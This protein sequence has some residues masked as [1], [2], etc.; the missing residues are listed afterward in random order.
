[1]RSTEAGN[2]PYA[3][4]IAN[5]RSIDARAI[6]IYDRLYVGRECSGVDESRRLLIDDPRASR[7]H[8]E[9]HIEPEQGVAYVIDSST[10]GTRLN[11][12]RIERSVPV[13][14]ESGDTLSVGVVPLEFHSEMLSN[15][16]AA[17][18]RTTTQVTNANFVMVVSD[19]VD[20][21][22]ASRA[23]EPIGHG[24]PRD[25]AGTLDPPREYHGTLS[26]FVGGALL[27]LGV[28]PDGR[29][30]ELPSIS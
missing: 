7:D 27:S 4:L 12:V 24:E 5:P 11:G 19:I 15:P 10:N 20:F 23:T 28:D 16:E 17:G 3:H 30:T 21:R 29:A 8:L 26:N 1:M 13:M 25:I 18:R 9:I 14:L 22:P 6:A 2:Q